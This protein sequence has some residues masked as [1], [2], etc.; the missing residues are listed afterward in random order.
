MAFEE[1]LLASLPPIEQGGRRFKRYYVTRETAVI[2]A[3]IEEAAFKLRD[4][5]VRHMLAPEV[6]DLDGYLADAM[7]SGRTG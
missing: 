6:A 7:P 1:K 3:E 4:A 5:W 2:T